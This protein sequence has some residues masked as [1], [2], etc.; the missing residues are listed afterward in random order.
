MGIDA[1]H[2]RASQKLIAQSMHELAQTSALIERSLS[3]IDR[4]RKALEHLASELETLPFELLADG[5]EKQQ[6]ELTVPNGANPP[7]SA[8][9]QLNGK[10]MRCANFP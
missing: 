8:V 6:Q 4:S 1:V 2:V 10:R 3:A 9:A 5:H 7:P